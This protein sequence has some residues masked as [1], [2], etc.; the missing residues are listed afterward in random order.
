MSFDKGENTSIL[1]ELNIPILVMGMKDAVIAASSDGILVSTREESDKIKPYVDKMDNMAM[2]EEKSWGSY[3]VLDIQDGNMTVK[4][5][6]RKGQSLSYHSHELRDEVWTIV[7]GTGY[8]VIDGEKKSL[9]PGDTLMIKSGVKHKAYAETELCII[10]NQI[11]M[12]LF[13]SDKIKFEDQ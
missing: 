11:G 10:E 1:N 4:I 12:K 2:F 3:T 13:A 7:S 8:A 5:T 9:E 6:L